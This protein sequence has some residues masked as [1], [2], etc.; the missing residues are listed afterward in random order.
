MGLSEEQAWGGGAGS[1]GA[2]MGGRVNIFWA[3]CILETPPYI[4]ISQGNSL[5]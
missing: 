4:K 5:Y 2:G 1:A 3:K